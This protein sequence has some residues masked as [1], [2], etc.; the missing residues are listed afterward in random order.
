NLVQEA[1]LNGLFQKLEE[2]CY[3]AKSLEICRRKLAGLQRNDLLKPKTNFIISHLSNNNPSI[4]ERYQ[5]T[6]MTEEIHQNSVFLIMPFYKNILNYSVT[7]K[8]TLSEF[9]NKCSDPEIKEKAQ[10]LRLVVA[11]KRSNVINKLIQ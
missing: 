4:L 7:I 11:Y 8:S 5:I 9:F 6:A 10:E 2:R 1:E 3:P